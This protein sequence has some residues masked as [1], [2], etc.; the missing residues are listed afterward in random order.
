M[1]P[2]LW[3]VPGRGPVGVGAELKC[4]PL[5]H[6]F[7]C[8]LRWP[9]PTLRHRPGIQASSLGA[10]LT[11][12]GLPPAVGKMLT[13]S[14]GAPTSQQRASVLTSVHYNNTVNQLYFNK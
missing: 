11:C 5:S 2:V 9:V 7:P 14:L 6:P 8:V 12:S 13:L 4:R 3:A 1:R 10:L